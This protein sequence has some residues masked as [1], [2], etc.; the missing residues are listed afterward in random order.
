M[1]FSILALACLAPS[2]LAAQ[3]HATAYARLGATWSSQLVEDVIVTDRITTQAAIAP[4][5]VLGG[6]MQVFPRYDAD[7]ELQFTTGSYSA[8]VSGQG[9]TDLGT[10]NTFSATLG[11]D[12]PLFEPR[13]R[14]RASVGV[15]KYL[16]SDD[17]GLF[18]QGGPLDFI[19]GAGA[20]YRRQVS[21]SLDV[22]VALRYDFHRFTTDE[23]QRQ[24]FSQSQAVHRVGL[25]VGIALGG[26]R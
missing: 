26:R 12:G 15:L 16:P 14:W 3:Q 2:A 24:G 6:A 25:T 4:T 11:L 19:V 17:T 13:F 1:R 21:S 9:T 7:L 23:L 8:D 10:L 5:I 18:L 20:D 22:S